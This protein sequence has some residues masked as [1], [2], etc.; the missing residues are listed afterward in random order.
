MD[1]K[2]LNVDLTVDQLVELSAQYARDYGQDNDK[3]V[4]VCALWEYLDAQSYLLLRKN[5]G[6]DDGDYTEVGADDFPEVVNSA[7]PFQ[8]WKQDSNLD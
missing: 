6:A 7:E 3:A 1:K 5:L 8:I 2:N 4:N